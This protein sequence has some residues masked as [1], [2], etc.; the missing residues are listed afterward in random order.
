MNLYNIQITVMQKQNLK[1]FTNLTKRRRIEVNEKELI[2]KA[3]RG[4][5]TQMAQRRD[6]DMKTV[7]SPPLG[8]LPW[9]LAATDGTIRKTIKAKLFELLS[10]KFPPA[11]TKPFW[12]SC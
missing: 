3:D 11:E 8:P 5:V 1:T 4:L 10:K 7:L 12:T 2:L 9:A 6:L